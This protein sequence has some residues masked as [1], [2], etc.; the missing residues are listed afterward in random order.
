LLTTRCPAS[1]SR[2]RRKPPVNTTDIWVSLT[3][4]ETEFCDQLAVDIQAARKAS[5]SRHTNNRRVT[6]S[7]ALAGQILGTRTECAAKTYLWMTAWHIE[8]LAQ[9]ITNICDLEHPRILIDV[10]GV[11][12]HDRQLISPAAAI[13]RNWAYLLVS[14]QE[15]PRYWIRGWC[16]GHE[17]AAAPLQ[18]LQPE[19]WCHALRPHE[20]RH[21]SELL[22]ICSG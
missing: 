8:L 18:E 19:R 13:K 1:S 10:K 5:G 15:H 3:P 7:Q 4:I 17:L 14:A 6:P 11:P 20:L 21:P 9:I 12:F 2:A 16:Y 22:A